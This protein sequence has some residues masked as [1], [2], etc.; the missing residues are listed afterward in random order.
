M[1]TRVLRAGMLVGLALLLAPGVA[2]AAEFRSGNTAV[3]GPGETVDGDVYLTGA[4]VRVEGQVRGDVFAAGQ[5]ILVTGRVEGGVTAAGATV[6]IDGQ[7]GGG[8]RAAGG[9]VRVAGQVQRD[10]LAGAGQ[11]E[12]TPAARI[13]GD[14]VVNSG[15]VTL[16]GQVGGSVTGT[17][18]T[19][20]LNGGVGRDVSLVVESLT[21]GPSSRIGG[22]LQYRSEREASIAS[23]AQVGTNRGRVP[24]GAP[25]S[26]TPQE[27]AFALAWGVVRSFL[28]VAG[29]GLV[30][31]LFAPGPLIASREALRRRPLA[32]LVAGLVTGLLFPVVLVVLLILT[33]LLAQLPLLVV[34]TA[35]VVSG[36]VAAGTVVA[37]WLGGILSGPLR[38]RIPAWLQL[39]L[40]AL[41]LALLSAV[42][43]LN[44]LVAVVV[45]VIGL[46]AVMVALLEG[47]RAAALGAATT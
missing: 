5:T 47:R 17:V 37:F 43:W 1:L 32:S 8:V 45:A 25:S 33:F 41:V 21:L 3:V 29:L 2:R 4:T 31:L 15:L 28:A 14:L 44:L 34:T 18:G 9:M 11:V 22:V 10:L 7:V 19:V 46:G 20:Q 30:G 36:L 42:P 35:L 38:S 24:S 27:Q 39:L 12:I 13:G 6:S 16:D 23:G 26:P 40:G